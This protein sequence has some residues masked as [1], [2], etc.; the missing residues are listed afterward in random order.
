[1]ALNY[2]MVGYLSVLL[3]YGG[4]QYAYASNLNSLPYN[5]MQCITIVVDRGN[6]K[7]QFYVNGSLWDTVTGIHSNNISPDGG[8]I[9]DMGYDR[10]GSTANLNIYSHKHYNIALSLSQVQQ[11]F[12]SER[13]KFGI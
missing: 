3:N 9:Y 8:D 1:M 6:T 13:A 5:V 11:N 4:N 2:P 7:I 10:G 12:N